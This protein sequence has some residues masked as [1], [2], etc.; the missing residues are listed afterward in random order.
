MTLLLTLIYCSTSV[1][2]IYDQSIDQQVQSTSIYTN[3]IKLLFDSLF[4]Y[5]YYVK[6]LLYVFYTNNHIHQTIQRCLRMRNDLECQIF[7]F[8]IQSRIQRFKR[9]QKAIQLNIV[10]YYRSNTI[11][12]EIV[13]GFSGKI[14]FP[15]FPTYTEANEPLDVYLSKTA[16]AQMSKLSMTDRCDQ[17]SANNKNSILFEFNTKLDLKRQAVDEF[18]ASHNELTWEDYHI[19]VHRLIKIDTMHLI[20]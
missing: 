18:M 19:L 5:P 6:P 1:Q 10:E 11:D 3:T 15:S 12:M 4:E 20:N 8:N 17:M 7:M 14:E 16:C 9:E 13:K 2:S